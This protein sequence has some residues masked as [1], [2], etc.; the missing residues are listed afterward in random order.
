MNR[1]SQSYWAVRLDVRHLL[2]DSSGESRDAVLALDQLTDE[3]Y[4]GEAW[5]AVTAQVRAAAIERS[6]EELAIHLG[7]VRSL[8]RKAHMVYLK[9]LYWGPLNLD[10]DRVEYQVILDSA[11]AWYSDR[12]ATGNDAVRYL[13][14]QRVLAYRAE[15][16]DEA[17]ETLDRLV[18]AGWPPYPEYLFGPRAVLAARLGDSARARAILDS[19]PPKDHRSSYADYD[20]HFFRA[21]V[22]AIL[23]EPAEAVAYLRSANRRGVPYEDIHGIARVDFATMWDYPPLQRL[24]AEH[25]CEGI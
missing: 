14:A 1:R 6:A 2:D 22:E 18:E 16:W 5:R 21:R 25:T 8:G 20:Q 9:L 13:F 12:P 10:P 17:A 19:M 7:E 3:L 11:R 23:G 24:L 4:P 15:N